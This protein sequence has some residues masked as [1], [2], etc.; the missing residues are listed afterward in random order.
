MA[1]NLK[2][3]FRYQ[4]IL[5]SWISTAT[6][7][8]VYPANVTIQTNTH[9]KKEKYSEAIDKV[10]VVVRAKKLAITNN[11]LVK[12]VM[13]LLNEKVILTESIDYAK[14]FTD[15]NIDSAVAL[16]KKKQELSRVFANMGAIKNTDAIIRGTDYK[17]NVA[18]DQVP[19]SYDIKAVTEIDF[20][21][22]EV[23]K[24]AKSLL[25][26]SDEISK[27]LDKIQITK[28]VGYSALY[29]VNST[30]EDI[31]EEYLAHG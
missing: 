16:N 29:D 19:Y 6:N 13:H 14:K 3:A 17:L 7:Y 22:N 30:F 25:N 18:G 11:D 31:V 5:D 8:L 26:E 1:M 24:I 23:K 20:D 27:E 21:R 28:T 15:I 12:L 10:E 9:M 4:N 2:E